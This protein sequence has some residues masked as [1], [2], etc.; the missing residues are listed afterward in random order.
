M[1]ANLK[2]R[3]CGAGGISK[4]YDA[5]EHDD[6]FYY[7]EAHQI[8]SG[9]CPVTAKLRASLSRC[10]PCCLVQEELES[11]NAQAAAHV[12]SQIEEMQESTSCTT[13][14][15]QFNSHTQW[16]D[17][18][19]GA[20]H[21]KRTLR[22]QSDQSI[23]SLVKVGSLMRLPSSP[24]ASPLSLK[25]DQPELDEIAACQE[26]TL[27][28][29]VANNEPKVLSRGGLW[30]SPDDARAVGLST[31]SFAP[32]AAVG[33]GSAWDQPAPPWSQW[34]Q[35]HQWQWQRQL[36]QW[37]AVQ[38]CQSFWTHQTDW[39]AHSPQQDCEMLAWQQRQQWKE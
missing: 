12:P 35:P 37:N 34:Q 28:E 15:L 9:S 24:V 29:A 26:A 17:H 3:A 36:Q 20:R 8:T 18:C 22:A 32:S 2:S 31:G 21:K 4:I 7:T 27:Q 1:Q 38:A 25:A 5:S 11:T 14:G 19:N 10:P 39:H 16:R 30:V 23:S 33:S 6:L 13:C